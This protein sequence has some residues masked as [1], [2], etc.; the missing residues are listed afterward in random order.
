MT[1]LLIWVGALLIAALM[2]YAI[3]YE[4][5]KRARMTEEEYEARAKQGPSL[6]SAGVLALDQVLRPE[7]EKAV[8]FRKDTERGQ[9]SD[10]ESGKDPTNLKE[11]EP[12]EAVSKN[13]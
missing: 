5:Q 1:E 13:E 11:P 9:V 2:I 8:A 12:G 7:L 3:I 10:Q 6:L 4:Q